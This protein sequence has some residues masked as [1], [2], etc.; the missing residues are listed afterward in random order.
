[1]PQAADRQAA[2]RPAAESPTAEGPA[3]K[4]LD[5]QAPAGLDRRTVRTRLALRDALADEIR[6]TGDLTRVTVTSVTERAGVT[7]RTFYSH[8]KDIP[9]LVNQVEGETI[10]DLRVLLADLT[11]VTLD[12]LQAALTDLGPCPGATPILTYFRDRGSYLAPLLGDGGDPAFATR[13]QSMAREVV[14]DR[15]LDGID[16]H[17]L[18][19]LFDY[20]LTYAISAEV[21]VLLRW[22]TSGMRQSVDVM[23]R[24]MTGLM[25]VRPGDLYDRPID[26]D[27][28][29]FACMMLAASG[30]N[31]ASSPQDSPASASLTTPAANRPEEDKR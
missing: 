22:L 17:V 31:D 23:A 25:F 13:I 29:Q 7:R 11:R 5:P 6:A 27:I 15:A 9:D 19:P 18:G 12:E 24:I 8:F 21:G 30:D 16:L 2:E 14:A 26:F 1:M 3:E 4:A 10:A 20:Y 28:T